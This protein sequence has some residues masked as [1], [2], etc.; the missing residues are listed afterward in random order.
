MY[1]PGMTTTTTMPKLKP[2][3]AD[4]LLVDRKRAGELLG[5]VS[6]STVERLISAGELTP[7]RLGRRVMLRRS[8]LQSFVDRLAKRAK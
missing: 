7:I 2:D 5:G 1:A 6:L 3:N 8:E 4:S